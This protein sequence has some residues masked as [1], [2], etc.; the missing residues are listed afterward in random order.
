MTNLAIIADGSSI[1]TTKIP[2]RRTPVVFPPKIRLFL[3]GWAF[4]VSHGDCELFYQISRRSIL[5][6][7]C[8]SLD[9][10]AIGAAQAW[11]ANGTDR[12][13]VAEPLEI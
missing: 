4:G 6:F 9:I 1:S 5:S 3:R 10:A 7:K 13:H 11:A 8:C 2:I 12:A